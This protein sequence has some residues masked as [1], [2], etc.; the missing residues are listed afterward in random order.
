MNISNITFQGFLLK[1]FLSSFYNTSANLLLQVSRFCDYMSSL[2]RRGN[3]F[4][5]GGGG[6]IP[7]LP[8][9][10]IAIIE[11]VRQHHCRREIWAIP[12]ANLTGEMDEP[13]LV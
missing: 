10:D 8:G 3:V 2:S 11:P 4:L 5:P 9:R 7:H 1:K 12:A 13:A 6:L